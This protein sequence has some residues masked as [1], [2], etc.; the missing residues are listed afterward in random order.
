M[1]LHSLLVADDVKEVADEI[2]Q[3]KKI[4]MM[5]HIQT[6]NEANDSFNR[7]KLFDERKIRFLTANNWINQKVNLFHLNGG[8]W[9]EYS[10]SL[11]PITNVYPLKEYHFDE[12]ATDEIVSNGKFRIE[13]DD[14][15]YNGE[16]YMQDYII[17][18]QNDPATLLPYKPRIKE[19]VFNYSVSETIDLVTRKNENNT[20]EIFQTLPY[21]F[22]KKKKEP[23]FFYFKH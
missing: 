1:I 5:K 13:L 20:V 2:V 18:S 21:G 6:I 10:N 7:S 16:K 9:I 8:K 14:A 3:A 23:L 19:F 15:D 11:E 17:A 22:A 4:I 12:V